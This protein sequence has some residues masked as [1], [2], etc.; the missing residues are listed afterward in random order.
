MAASMTPMLVQRL[1]CLAVQRTEALLNPAVQCPHVSFIPI[2]T[3]KRYFIPPAV[4]M[5]GQS[6]A[7]QEARARQAGVVVRQEYFERAIN[8]TCTAGVYD[9]Y[10]PPEGDARLSGLSKEGLKQRAESLRQSAA[11]QLAIRKIKEHDPEFR[12]KDFPSQA[13]DLFIQAHSALTE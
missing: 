2:R 9:A 6:P 12:T 4:G 13:Q 1:K 3:K 11:S 8:I 5:K 10:I 7:S